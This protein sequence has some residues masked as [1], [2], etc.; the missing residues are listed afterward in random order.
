MKTFRYLLDVNVLVAHAIL[1]HEHHRIAITG[2]QRVSGR[3]CKLYTCP[4]VELG[5]LRNAMRIGS[6]TLA[7]GLEL[8]A[9]ERINLK[10]KFI[11][12]AVDVSALPEWVQG[13]RQTTDAY[14]SALAQ[15]SGLK[16]MTIDKGIPGAERLLPE[17]NQ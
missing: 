16:L 17:G 14:L 3:G 15:A 8:V 13:Y 5:L 2:L 1:E 10:L 9:N 6:L 4:I 12:D 11:A 7:E